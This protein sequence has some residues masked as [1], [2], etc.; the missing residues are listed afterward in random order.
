MKKIHSSR[1][2]IFISLFAVIIFIHAPGRTTSLA[3]NA[4]TDAQSDLVIRNGRVLDGA[5]MIL[6]MV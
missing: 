4:Q 6:P 3:A 2:S 1:L 5:R